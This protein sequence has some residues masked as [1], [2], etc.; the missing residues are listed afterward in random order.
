MKETHEIDVVSHKC[1]ALMLS[2]EGNGKP[3]FGSWNKSQASVH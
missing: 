2:S 3:G 1:L